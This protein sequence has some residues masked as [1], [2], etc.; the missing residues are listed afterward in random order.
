M[1][2]RGRPG[3]IAAA[4]DHHPIAVLAVPDHPLIHGANAGDRRAGRTTVLLYF[5][6][7]AVLKLRQ[8]VGRLIRRSDDMGIITTPGLT[9][10]DE[11]LRKDL[12][13]VAAKM[14]GGDSGEGWRS[15]GI[16]D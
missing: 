16:G 7:E 13:Q 9:D 11:E 6:P 1:D 4:C 14:Q 12:S 5:L 3:R 15:G 2:G 10:R 8:G